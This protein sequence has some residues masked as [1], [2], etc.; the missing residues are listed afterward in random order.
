MSKRRERK[1][2]GER[3]AIES[4]SANRIAGTPA[5]RLR[6]PYASTFQ[7]SV[8]GVAVAL[9]AAL[10]VVLWNRSGPFWRDEC[11]SILLS[12]AP[13]WTDLW[14]ELR[15]DSFPA[16]FVAIL[17]IWTMAGPGM[18]EIGL[19]ILGILIFVGTLVSVLF[20]CRSMGVK[21]PVLAIAMTCLNSTVLYYGTTIRAYGLAS[22]LIVACFAVFWRFSL[23]PTGRNAGLAL[24]LAVLSVHSNYQNCYLLF[25]IGIASALVC[26]LHGAWGRC[27]VVL[28]I[29]LA[30]ALSMLIYMPVVLRYREDMSISHFSLDARII[31]GTFV[32]AVGGS[33]RV[34]LMIWGALGVAALACAA[35]EVF[36]AVRGHS[37]LKAS[38]ATPPFYCAMTIVIAAATGT[39]FFQ[40]NGMYPFVWHYL[41]FIVLAGV[42]IDCGIQISRPWRWLEPCKC[43]IGCLVIVGSLLPTWNQVRMRRTNVDLIAAVLEKEAR[44]DDLILVNPFWLRPSVKQYY[45]GATMWRTVPVDPDDPGLYWHGCGPSVKRMML[46]EDSIG[47]T[48][49]LVQET[50]R[51]GGR[52]WIIG[53][54]QFLPPGTALPDLL[55]APHP[56]YGWDNNA[57]SE[58]WSLYLGRFLSQNAQKANLVVA[59]QETVSRLE[60][61]SLVLVEGW[62]GP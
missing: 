44:K 25:G 46:R 11:A 15:T 27:L 50:L 20:S 47:P 4:S 60:N 12:R 6:L 49:Q 51:R 54:I 21:T 19:H 45:R 23:R 55:P 22:L 29:C 53:G 52:L 28:A 24:L 2:S 61:M 43:A 62:R 40:I 38:V 39:V 41:P 7:W 48:D 57:Y 18:T 58:I 56:K 17:R 31:G 34:L 59:P 35:A 13:S 33:N 1:Q 26:L 10:L 3:V 30:A 8:L 16:L 32:E 14:S 9:I 42:A 37:S 5:G 36:F